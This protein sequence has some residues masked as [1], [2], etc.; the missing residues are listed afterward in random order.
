LKYYL[1]SASG[2]TRSFVISWS[3]LLSRKKN[4]MRVVRGQMQ[5]MEEAIFKLSLRLMTN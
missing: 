5:T 3:L 4:E 2:S 1:L